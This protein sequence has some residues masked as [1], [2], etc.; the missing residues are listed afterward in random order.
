MQSTVCTW[1]S[2]QT[3]LGPVC[4]LYRMPRPLQAQ[5]PDRIESSVLVTLLPVSRLLQARSPDCTGLKTLDP[6]SCIS[7]WFKTHLLIAVSVSPESSDCTEHSLQTALGPVSR[8]HWDQS[9]TTLGPVTR[10]Q[11]AK[12]QDRTYLSLQIALGTVYR[13]HSAPLSR[14]HR[15]LY[16]DCTRPSLQRTPIPVS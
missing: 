12:S 16:L 7:L 3:A 13:P 5:S 6:A 9:P 4:R 8:L 11:W 10:L 1:L 14:R 15:D 2:V